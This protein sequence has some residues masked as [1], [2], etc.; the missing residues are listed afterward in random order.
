M[1]LRVE[2][3]EPSRSRMLRPT[4]LDEVDRAGNV[5]VDDAQDI[6]EILIEKTFAQSTPGI[7]QQRLDWTI[8]NRRIELVD[9]VDLREFGLQG[10]DFAPSASKSL[11]AL[12]ISGSPYRML[13]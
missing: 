2:D 5:G 4:F 13:R 7:G 3:G 9:A 6:I 12:F 8:A 10:L 11:P 1:Q